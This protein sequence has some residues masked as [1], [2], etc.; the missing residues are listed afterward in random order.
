LISYR[1]PSIFGGVTD[2]PQVP[3]EIVRDLLAIARVLYATRLAAQ[4]PATELAQLEAA[5]RALATSLSLSHLPSSTIGGRAAWSWAERGLGLLASALCEEDASA[6]V[7]V[8]AWG[9]RLR[10]RS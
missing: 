3:S 10:G 7:F 9:V 4:A 1:S 2:R 5:G 6:R 8:A